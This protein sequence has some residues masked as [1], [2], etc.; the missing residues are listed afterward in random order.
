VFVL[1]TI[2][3][4]RLFYIPS[5]GICLALAA[6]SE[7]WLAGGRRAAMVAAAVCAIVVAAVAVDRH[8][9]LE[10]LTPVSLF[11]AAA[12]SGP[13]SARAHMELASAYGTQGRIDEALPHFTSALAIKP[14]YP[15][16]AYNQGNTLARAGRFDDAAAAYRH[17]LA[18]DA[19]FVRAWHNLALVERA[20]GNTA[21]WVD[22]LE[23]AAAVAPKSAVVESDL[24]EALLAA[25]RYEDA[26]KAYDAVVATGQAVAATYFNRGVARHHLGGCAAAVED[27]RLAAAQPAAPREVFVA[28]SRCLQELGR[29]E[30]AA[31]IE[32]AAKVANRDTRR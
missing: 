22:A 8:R 20:R 28:A 31:S 13:R 12:R 19:K 26:V 2:L 25:G 9:C 3:G 10:W 5:A 6:L 27:Y 15:V 16:A 11:E 18:L 4:E 21:G 23:S 1:G 17:A 7:P 14:D 29:N 30:E 24:G 32:Q